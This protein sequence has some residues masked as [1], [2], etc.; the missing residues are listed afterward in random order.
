M[1]KILNGNPRSRRSLAIVARM[2]K[3][4]KTDKVKRLKKEDN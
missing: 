3:P 1:D 2:K 4:C